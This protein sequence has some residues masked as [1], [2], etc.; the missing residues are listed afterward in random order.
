M[1]ESKEKKFVLKYV[2]HKN[3]YKVFF[4]DH[5]YNP[6]YRDKDGKKTEVEVNGNKETFGTNLLYYLRMNLL[7]KFKSLVYNITVKHSYIVKEGSNYIVFYVPCS[8]LIDDKY[9]D[10]FKEALSDALYKASKF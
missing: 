8:S 6:K 3:M 4:S 5:Y 1:R 10:I 7:S 9:N 2:S